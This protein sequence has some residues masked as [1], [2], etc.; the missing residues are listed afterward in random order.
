[1]GWQVRQ[2]ETFVS[3]PR[4]LMIRSTTWLLYHE[5]CNLYPNQRNDKICYV[6]SSAQERF[7]LIQF[8]RI[9]SGPVRSVERVLA[10][11]GFAYLKTASRNS[12]QLTTAR[13]E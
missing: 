12:A 10:K 3:S 1:M 5:V 6:H 13:S 7:E 4:G 9:Q 11:D 8:P 2:E